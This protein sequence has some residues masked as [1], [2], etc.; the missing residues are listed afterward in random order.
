MGYTHY[1]Y[2]PKE[3]S[4][5]TFKAIVEDFRKLQ[6]G[7]ASAGIKL[8]GGSGEGEP[9]FS[10]DVV[11][12]NGDMHCGH[13]VNQE[14]SIPWPSATAGGVGNSENAISGHW[15]AGATLETR[16]C[17]GDCSYE[18]FHFPRVIEEGVEPVRQEAWRTSEGE[19][20]YTLKSKVG[21]YFDCCKTAYRPYDIAV[22]A[23]LIIAKMRLGRKIVVSSDGE[24][25]HWFE[26]AFLC[27][28]ALGYGPDIKVL[29]D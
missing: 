4:R 29:D 11:V 23:F 6:P 13:E 18:T 15:Y 27:Q 9:I 24:I 5:A 21:K 8:A 26:G 20:V 3:I 10:D 25:Q 19:V 1:W 22:T 14:V 17:N 7:L 2:R 12:F 16:T 28:S